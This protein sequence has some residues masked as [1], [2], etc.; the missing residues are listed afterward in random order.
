MLS[1]WRKVATNRPFAL[2]AVAMIGSYVLSFQVYL[3]LPLQ[4]KVVTTSE[5]GQVPRSRGCS[6]SPGW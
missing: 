3:A 4:A 6:P 1:T 5:L 2:F